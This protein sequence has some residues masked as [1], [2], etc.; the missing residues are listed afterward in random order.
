MVHETYYARRRSAP[1]DYATVITVHEMIHELPLNESG[2][3]AK[4]VEEKRVAISRA[5]RVICVSENTR[6]DLLNLYGI[7][8]DKT[9][10][11]HQVLIN[12]GHERLARFSWAKC[13]EETLS[14]YRELEV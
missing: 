6:Q 11:V 1:K 9:S 3:Q 5:D 13:A 8:E 2:S 14:V 4:T 10:V 12:L 7:R